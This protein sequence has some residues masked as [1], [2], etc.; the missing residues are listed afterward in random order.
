MV[1][2]GHLCNVLL[3]PFLCVGMRATRRTRLSTGP[4]NFGP[5]CCF[6]TQTETWSGLLT[7]SMHRLQA[8]PH[9]EQRVDSNLSAALLREGGRYLAYGRPLLSPP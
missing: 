4:A 2:L 1:Q 9:G 6:R 8:V 7:V 5:C 3:A